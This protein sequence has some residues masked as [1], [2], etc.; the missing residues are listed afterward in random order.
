MSDALAGRDGTAYR[1]FMES[2]ELT[3]TELLERHVELLHGA[4]R[5]GCY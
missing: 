5:T 1:A 2:G 4:G 3:A